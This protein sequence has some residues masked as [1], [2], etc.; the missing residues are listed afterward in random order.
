MNATSLLLTTNDQRLTTREAQNKPNS[1][2]NKANFQ[3]VLETNAS[4][5]VST[6]EV[7]S[8]MLD[9]GSWMNPFLKQGKL[10]E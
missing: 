8:W 3:S 7:Q 1:N 9:V 4:R 5:S 2:P 6:L 10:V